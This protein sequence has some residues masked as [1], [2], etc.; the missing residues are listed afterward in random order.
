MRKPKVLLGRPVEGMGGIQ[1]G[2]R[3]RYSPM[4]MREAR[5]PAAALTFKTP[6]MWRLSRVCSR[7]VKKRK[8][9]RY[10]ARS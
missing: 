7:T 9:V 6:E 1:D 3:P 5:A 2:M 10:F 4:P 8:E